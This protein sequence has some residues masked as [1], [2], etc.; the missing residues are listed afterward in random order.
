MLDVSGYLITMFLLVAIIVFSL[1]FYYAEAGTPWHTYITVFSCYYSAFMI[2][3]IIP[4]DVAKSIEDRRYTGA[5][6]IE[7]Y[8]NNVDLIR[9][10]YKTLYLIFT[11]LASFVLVLEELYNS[12]GI[13]YKMSIYFQF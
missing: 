8:R 12:D 11:I 7:N 5:D 10:I 4:L 9:P 13:N 3:F 2:L 6:Y 1:I